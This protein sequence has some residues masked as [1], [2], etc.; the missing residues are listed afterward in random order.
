VTSNCFLFRLSTKT[1]GIVYLSIYL[2]LSIIIY[3]YMQVSVG[4]G[5]SANAQSNALLFG[6]KS[7]VDSISRMPAPHRGAAG[8]GGA[9]DGGG[10]GGSDEWM[11]QVG[12]HYVLYLLYVVLCSSIR[13]CALTSALAKKKSCVSQLLSP[14]GCIENTHK[15]THRYIRTHTHSQHC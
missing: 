13:H 4:E 8:A 14:N 12:V 7:F 6:L 10:G 5:D 9:G 3:I 2:S 11:Q 15:H 1:I